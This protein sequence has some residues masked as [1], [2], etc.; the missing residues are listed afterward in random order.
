MND[1]T[2]HGRCLCGKVRMRIEGEPIWVGHCHCQSCRRNTGSA[3]ATFVAFRPAQVTY[4]HGER[5]FFASSPG[6]QRGFCAHCGTP[7]SYE[8]EKFPNETHLY[9]CTLDEP[10][11]FIPTFHVFCEERVPWFEIADDL[12]RHARTTKG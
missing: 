1:S 4:T 7:L 2:T 10:G 3:V 11:K 12:P 9:L 5:Q 8:A 6:V